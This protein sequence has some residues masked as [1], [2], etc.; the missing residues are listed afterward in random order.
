MAVLIG[1]FGLV[2]GGIVPFVVFP[3]FDANYVTATVTFPSG[4]P[5]D[6]TDEATRRMADGDR[7]SCT[8]RSPRSRAAAGPDDRPD[9]RL[10]RAGGARPEQDGVH[11]AAANIGY[12]FVELVDG[13]VRP[14]GSER[15]GRA[16]GASRS[17][18]S[19]GP[20]RSSSPPATPGPAA[21][22]SSSSSSARTSTSWRPSPTRCKEH[23]ADFDG[24]FDIGDNTQPGKPEFQLR[25]RPEAEALGIDTNELAMTVRST[26]YGEEVMR[27]QRG[28]HEVK[29]MVRYP[30]AERARWPAS[31]SLRTEVRVRHPRRGAGEVPLEELAAG[32]RPPRLLGHQPDRPEPLDH[33]HRRPGR[34]RRPTPATS[35]RNSR[36]SSC[37]PCCRIT[38]RPRPLGGAGARDAGVGSSLMVGFVVALFAMFVLLTAQFRSYLQPL[39]VMLIIPFGLVGAIWGTSSW[40]AQR[41]RQVHAADALQHVRPGGAGRR[42]GQRLDRADRL[43]QR[44]DSREGRRS[45]RRCARP[46]GSGSGRCC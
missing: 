45:A 21:S 26:F 32:R 12:V 22:R 4:T 34:D 1:S 40:P 20:R 33:R 13:E 18:R 9:A 28:R 42:G 30:P 44:P 27:L 31:A 14:I 38:R 16:P 24:V 10:R 19:P 39:F 2:A 8:A 17:G 25:V 29:L 7:R 23:L 41:Q 11:A 35:S 3:K 15:A 43:H 36:T 37:P 6:V 46:A 5:A